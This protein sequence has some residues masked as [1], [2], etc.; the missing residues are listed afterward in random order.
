MTPPTSLPEYLA[1]VV[2]S[3]QD[4]VVSA[5]L[6]RRIESWNPAAERLLGYTAA[7]AIGQPLSILLPEG[8]SHEQF[9]AFQ[10]LMRDEVPGPYETVRRRR[11]GQLI[12]VLVSVS[13]IR[14]AAGTMIGAAAVIRSISGRERHEQ[15]ERRLSAIVASSDDAI[16]SKDLDGTVTSWNRAAERI[17]GYTAAD[18]VGQSIRRIIPADRQNEE[19]VVLAQVRAGKQVSHFETVRQRKDGTLVDVSVTV[20]PIHDETGAVMGASK[21]ARDITA[22]RHAAAERER[23]LQLAQ[24]ESTVSATLHAAGAIVA[25]TLDRDTIVQA[26]TDHATRATGA[27]FGAFF[28]NAYDPESGENFQ[29]YTLSGAP[30]EAFSQFPHP[31]ATPIF[32]PT[33]KGEGVVRLDDVL[34]DPRYGR[35]PPYHGMPSGHLPVRSYLAV[36]VKT[37]A[38]DVLGGLFFGHSSPGVFDDTHERLA[39]GMAAWASVALENASLYIAAQDANRL[40]DEFLATFSHE[41]RTPL[42]AVLGYARLLKDALIPLDRQP[43]AIESIERNGTALAQIV[44]D[45][46]DVARITT[47][48][49]R[50]NVGDVDVAAVL[51]H[52][53]DAF[54][55][56]AEAKGI[57]LQLVVDGDAGPV[58]GDADRLQQ[59]FANLLSNA[60]KFTPRGGRVQAEV[61]R[62]NSSVEASVSDTGI[63]IAP[64]FLPHVF[65]RFRQADG[66]LQRGYGGLGLGLSIA[67]QLVELHGGTLEAHSDGVGLGASFVVQVPLKVAK[68]ARSTG[69]RVHPSRRAPEVTLPPPRLDGTRVLVVDDEPDA[70]EL[71]RDLLESAGARVTTAGSAREGLQMLADDGLDVVLADLG[72][73]YEDGYAFI[74]QIRSHADDR[75]R[76]VPAAALT[77]FARS[78]DR[79][80]ALRSGFQLHLA[81]PVD[82]GEL[83][84]AVAAL[85]LR[86]QPPGPDPAS[87]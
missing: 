64:G 50:L 37:R 22:Q 79:T 57:R 48:K 76:G 84:A 53:V 49:L 42:N 11:D 26:V 16:V 70:R 19:D 36:P 30:R 58:S 40:K 5:D 29:L 78:E 38:G 75:V 18:M 41:L 6:D 72:M 39:V 59:V 74:R 10:A 81:K 46:L 31:R 85:T 80:R 4:A 54:T 83:M 21:I 44:D 71:V 17:F 27:E 67:K 69:P 63:G 62:V 73:P 52:A 3:S 56:A 55:P 28:Y 86:P 25:A 8:R 15:A 61:R 9:A 14:N 20:S 2:Q 45:V 43:R 47:G 13:P 77:A 1:F 87:S 34:A 24:Q 23:L 32:A 12:H 60:I 33:F 7:E 66:G 82:P 65:E 68:V 35:M 51:G